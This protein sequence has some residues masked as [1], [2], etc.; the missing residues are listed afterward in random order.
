MQKKYNNDFPFSQGYGWI[1]AGRPK[2]GRSFT[3]LEKYIKSDH[4]KPFYNIASDATHSG[5]KGFNRIGLW[6][7]IQSQVL[8][9]GPTD[10]GFE[11][12]LQNTIIR[13]GVI[14]ACLL[15]IDSNFENILE[16]SVLHLIYLK[17]RK[18]IGNSIKK[19][20]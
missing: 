5:A 9:T 2:L 18:L 19:N 7:E 1:P 17:I 4:W 11:D 6:D 16:A 20:T 3:D 15:T 12:P 8:L 13:L 10:Y 14:N